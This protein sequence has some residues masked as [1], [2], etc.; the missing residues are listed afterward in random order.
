MKSVEEQAALIERGAVD[1]ISREELVKKL[2]RSVETGKPM[3]IKAGFDPTAPDLHLGH[4][5]LLQKLRHFQQLGHQ[6]VFLIGDF[7]GLIGDPTGKSDTRPPLTREDVER[8]AET[9]KEQVFKILD[10]EKTRVAF[11]STWLGELSSYE[12]IRL[13]SRLTVARML[14]RDDF[15]KRFETNRPISIHEFLY[16]LIQGYDSVALEADVEIGGT[17]QLF[18]LLMG[19]DLQKGRNQEPQVVL[20]MPLLEGLDGV[21]KMSKSLGNYI[22][23]SESPDNIFG[24]ILSISDELMFR[25]Y[26]LLSDLSMD[27]ITL[28]KQDMEAG[29][30]HPKAVKVRL[31]RELV[32]R[33]HDADAADAAERNFEQVFKK[34]ALPDEI[35]EKELTMDEAAV[36]LPKLLVQAELVK[37]TSDGRRMITQNAVAVDGRKVTDINTEIP[38][39]GSVLLQVGKRRICRVIF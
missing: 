32:T 11:N 26:E 35:P 13:A 34:H 15:K 31:A 8:N 25:Y 7:T 18:N 33:F 24:K 36:W 10:P 12:M 2:T 9:Y 38:A 17:D 20:T 39:R 19:R 1:L 14:E 3:V 37:S 21:N 16:P 23:I 29:K 4:T 6:I 5:V 30:I 27:E 28:L 22:G